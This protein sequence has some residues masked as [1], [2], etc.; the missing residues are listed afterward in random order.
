[1]GGR[2]CLSDD[3]HG[4]AQVGL[5]YGRMKM[6]LEEMGV[7]EIWY[8]V[9]EGQ[10]QDGEESVGSRGRVVA[11]RMKGSYMSQIGLAPTAAMKAMSNQV[12][13]L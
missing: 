10:R 9:G 4:V 13:I 1:M 8:L 5:N 11:R 7:E 3:S 6:Y 2:I 12:V